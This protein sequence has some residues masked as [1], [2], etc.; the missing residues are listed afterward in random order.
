M[1]ASLSPVQL[2]CRNVFVSV[3]TVSS[4]TVPRAWISQHERRAEQQAVTIHLGCRN[5]R[6][7]RQTRGWNEICRNGHRCSRGHD[8]AV[9]RRVR[10]CSSPTSRRTN[11]HSFQESLQICFTEVRPSA[12]TP[13]VN[14][15]CASLQHRDGTHHIQQD[16]D[17]LLQVTSWSVFFQ[18]SVLAISIGD[19][20]HRS[21]D[22]YDADA[23]ASVN[24]CSQLALN[25]IPHKIGQKTDDIGGT[26]F[27]QSTK[28]GTRYKVVR[29]EQL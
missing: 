15:T 3:S 1:W 24:L 14:K 18:C 9:I 26:C 21:R 29:A 20:Q 23:T 8:R 4:V 25:T 6:Q 2:K 7:D 22:V 27:N 17:R 5:R 12:S 19:G 28:I 16:W 11:T 13:Q 10:S